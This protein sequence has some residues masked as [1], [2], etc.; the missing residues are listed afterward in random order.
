MTVAKDIMTMTVYTVSENDTLRDAWYKLVE[1]RISG[2]PVVDAQGNV[3]GVITEKD[4]LAYLYP[5]GKCSSCEQHHERL[6]NFIRTTVGNDIPDIADVTDAYH[7]ARKEQ[8]KDIMSQEV[9]SGTSTDRVEAIIALMWEN[10]IN[11]IPILEDRKVVGIVTIT[12][13]IRALVKGK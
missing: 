1:H 11:R 9:I 7:K 3:M 2:A 6:K 12:D 13:V 5:Y 10:D 4:I 8:V